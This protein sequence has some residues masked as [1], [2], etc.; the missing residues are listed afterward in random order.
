MNYYNG[1]CKL[2]FFNSINPSVFIDLLAFSN[3]AEL[4]LPPTVINLQ[5]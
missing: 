5:K 3:N 1:G 2:V 4:S